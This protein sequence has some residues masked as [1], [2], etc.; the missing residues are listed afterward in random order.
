[1]LRGNKK[2][3]TEL[4]LLITVFSTGFMPILVSAQNDLD[5]H[6]KTGPFADKI[7]YRVITQDDQQVLALQDDEIDLIGD[8]VNPSFL[9]TL[10]EAENI[11]VAT[12]LRN[13]YGY[14]SINTEKYP[15]NITAFRRAF[16]FALDKERISED[17]WDGLSVSQDSCVPQDNPFSIEGLLDYNYY[18]PNVTLG[19]QLLDAAGFLDVNS[20]NFREAPN[21]SAFEVG[22]FVGH[23]S[24]IANEVGDIAVE[25]LL[26][27]GIDAYTLI[28]DW[29]PLQWSPYWT[30]DYDMV[31]LGKSYENFDVDWLAYG[32]RSDYSYGFYWNLSYWRNTSYESWSNQLINSSTYEEVYEAAIE[33][34]R[35]FV[36]ECPIVV[37]YENMLLSA[38]RTDRFDGFVNDVNDGIPSWWT[39]Y[40]VHLKQ[41]EGGPFGGFLRRSN[42][43]DISSFNFMT[44]WDKYTMNILQ[45]MYDSLI[46]QGPD[47]EDV[48]WLAKSYTI[49]THSDNPAISD[50][51]TRLTFQ[52]IENATW[53]DGMPLTSED[54]ASTLRYYRDSPSNLYGEYLDDMITAYAPN[55][56]SLVVEFESESFWHL[57]AVGYKPILPKHLIDGLDWAIYNP[58]PPLDPMV[59]SGPFNVSFYEAGE[60]VE[61]TRNPSYFYNPE[62]PTPTTTT[63]DPIDPR[64]YLFGAIAGVFLCV[65][66]IVLV[67]WKL[68]QN[69]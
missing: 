50:G 69:R 42:P 53:S 20:D 43:L 19:N 36:Y 35:I 6:P 5:Y 25:A 27:L 63:P 2:R 59:T 57:H 1:M 31:F 41:N 12:T 55:P 54:V 23:S 45:M 24:S 34:Q 40:K 64:Y 49:E 9:E 56:Y 37:M 61:L 3:L 68:K 8:L 16:A 22:V 29:Y 52:L 7:I 48:M 30:S 60:Y 17:V 44:S 13:G 47:G 11:D 65:I 46:K 66:V 67:N 15:L 38:Y 33:M 21:G 18:S 62:I 58:N 4:I 28:D 26:S 10:T 14:L 51:N 32:F 39:N